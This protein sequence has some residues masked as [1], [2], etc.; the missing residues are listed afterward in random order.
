MTPII[1]FTALLARIRALLPERGGVR[2]CGAVVGRR[3]RAHV[4]GHGLGAPRARV[5]ALRT[6]I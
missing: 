1:R 4:A 5:A 6:L 2:L 3:P